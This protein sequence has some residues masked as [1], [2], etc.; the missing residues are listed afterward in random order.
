MSRNSDK[1]TDTDSAEPGA[2]AHQRVVNDYFKIT[3]GVIHSV[4]NYAIETA[5][6]RRGLGRWL[7]VGGKKVVDLGSGTGELCWLLDS[8]SAASV[9][10]VNL[11]QEEIDFAKPYVP[12]QFV[13]QDIIEYLSSCPDESV[14]GI[15]ALNILEHLS[16]DELVLLLDNSRRV[17]VP[18]GR[19]V[20]M[21]PNG[22]SP[23]G[24]MTRYWDFTHL[25]A[26]T[27]SSVRQLM[28]LSG[29]S[30]VEFMEW[31]PRA[32][33]VKSFIRYV[34]WQLIRLGIAL[35]LIIETG[36]SKG[37]IYTS[38]MIFRLTK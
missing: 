30:C 36:S 18:G 7:D 4:R 12:V 24:T 22:T 6:L 28:R 38:D 15:F 2:S 29:F 14:D 17:L 23:Y 32:Y 8:L 19:L 11:S 34:L 37:G 1:T 16:R 20:A 35:R 21:V 10:G 26:F 9:V 31:G 27:P 5:G 3:S 33:G 25:L 13:C